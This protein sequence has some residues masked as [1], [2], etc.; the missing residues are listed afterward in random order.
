VTEPIKVIK[1][2]NYDFE[3][4]EISKENIERLTKRKKNTKNEKGGQKK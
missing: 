3:W 4:V 2:V 1:Y